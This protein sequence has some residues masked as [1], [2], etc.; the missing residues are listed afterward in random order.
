MGF[1]LSPVKV[2]GVLCKKTVRL[3]IPEPYLGNKHLRRETAEMPV[4]YTSTFRIPAEMAAT[5][6]Y[7]WLLIDGDMR[8][9]LRRRF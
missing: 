8:Q 1:A 5:R 7:D 6:D 9:T 3:C 4:G 2:L